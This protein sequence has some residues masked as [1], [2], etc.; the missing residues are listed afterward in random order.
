MN[1]EPHS[2]V[3]MIMIIISITTTF[4]LSLQRE[5]GRLYVTFRDLE[6]L[7]CFIFRRCE[8]KSNVRKIFQRGYQQ[9]PAFV[10]V[11]VFL[12]FSQNTYLLVCLNVGSAQV[13]NTYIDA[14]AW[15]Q[16]RLC[17]K[18]RDLGILV[19]RSILKLLF[20]KSMTF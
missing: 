8:G 12:L 20:G 2:P 6:S 11:Q 18:S 16:S 15:C 4:F 10:Y 5:R 17:A 14:L 3:L 19:P 13:L 7:L 9:L 1:C